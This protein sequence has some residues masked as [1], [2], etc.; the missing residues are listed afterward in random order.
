M[1]RRPS[2]LVDVIANVKAILKP[3]KHQSSWALMVFI[4]ARE[5]RQQRVSGGD[6]SEANDSNRGF[7]SPPLLL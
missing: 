7:M 1:E 4:K 6:E 2:F 5:E 3:S